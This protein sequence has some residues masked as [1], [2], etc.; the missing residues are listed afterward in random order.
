MEVFELVV[1]DDRVYSDLPFCNLRGCIL[2]ECEAFEILEV[3]EQI[4]DRGDVGYVDVYEGETAE[5]ES[6][7]RAGILGEAPEGDSFKV[8]QAEGVER[9]EVLENEVIEVVHVEGGDA[10]MLEG[11]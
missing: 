2:H 8:L 9:G 6:V 1:R 3:E 10:E 4:R 7:A 5:G 11:G